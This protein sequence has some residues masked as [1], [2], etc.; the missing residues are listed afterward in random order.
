MYAS[1]LTV[2]VK[3]NLITYSLLSFLYDV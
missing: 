3:P 1:P 2:M